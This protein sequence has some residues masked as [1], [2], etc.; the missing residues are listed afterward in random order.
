M[1]ANGARSTSRLAT[2]PFLFVAVAVAAIVASA[3]PAAATPVWSIVVSPNPTG[4]FSQVTLGV[5]SCPTTTTCFAIGQALPKAGG[6][7]E[8]FV[9]QWNGHAWSVVTTP[10]PPGSISAILEGVT[11]TS[12][13][14]CFAVG[15]SVSAS[16]ATTL[17][18][19]WDGSRWSIMTS[20][21][22][23]SLPKLS[24]PTLNAV[25]CLSANS[26]FAVGEYT[27]GTAKTE[28]TKTL[29]APTRPVRPCNPF[30][31]R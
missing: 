6:A 29:A 16:N 27:F 7:L 31:L 11:C 17:V 18:E 15:G 23:S 19:R 4:S 28:R 1:R 8:S 9:E 21:N 13:T 2:R 14:T 3:L 5:V 26:C 10:R 20:A 22:L 12:A 24:V 25:S 30:S